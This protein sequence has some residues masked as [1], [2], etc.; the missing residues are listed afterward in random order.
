M[1][2]W[3]GIALAAVVLAFPAWG[4]EAAVSSM[5]R[6]DQELQRIGSIRDQKTAELDA[7]DAACL[8]KFAVTDCQNKVAAQ[9]RQML[10]DLKRQEST[11]K[12]AQRRQKA[13]DQMQRSADKA[14]EKAQREAELQAGEKA[15]S[16]SDRQ[17]TQDDK[18]QSHRQQAKPAEPKASA[19]KLASD[20]DA[21]TQAK[22]RAAYQEKMRATEKRRQERAQRVRDHG[23]GGPPLPATP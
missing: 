7:Q 19:P 1:K 12:D 11:V 10:A 23:T 3:M 13:A 16:E 14:A 21:K 15:E 9:R 17:K 4:Q 8:K 22:N 6:F 18:V 5:D 20:L 2:P